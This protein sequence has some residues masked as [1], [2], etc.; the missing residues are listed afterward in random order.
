MPARIVTKLGTRFGNRRVIK[1]RLN[2]F[3]S[4]CL[5]LCKC[6][7]K[8]W[9]RTANLRQGTHPTCIQCAAASRGFY[10]HPKARVLIPNK[11]GCRKV[12]RTEMQSGHTRIL[13]QCDCDRKTWIPTNSTKKRC[14]G[15]SM[16][17]NANKFWHP[18]LTTAELRRILDI[19]IAKEQLFA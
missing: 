17:L 6:G 18:R 7:A 15:C 10:T 4:E 14:T 3:S 5:M 16:V 19:K 1:T 13:V 9:L 2:N 8:K 12:I 11:I